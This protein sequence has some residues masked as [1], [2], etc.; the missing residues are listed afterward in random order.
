MRE[1]LDGLVPGLPEELMGRIL[2]QAEGVPLYAVETVRML[3]D[4][5][6]LTQDGSR[7]VLTGDVSELDVPETLQALS[8]ARLDGL[9]PNERSVLQDA[10]VFGQSFTAAGVAALGGRSP[11]EAER[12]LGGLVTKQLLGLN[13][14]P[15]S[16]ER[17]QYHFLQG[18]L[19]GT[20]YGTLSRRDRKARHLSA[21]RH[22]QEIWGEAAPE[23]A[24]ILAAH[25]LDAAAADPEASDAGRIRAAARDTLADAGRRALSLALGREAQRAFDRA[26]E[27]AE[28]DAS[29]AALLDQAG[30]AA[31]MSADF[32]Q[33]LTRLEEAIEIYE[34][35]GDSSAAARAMLPVGHALFREDRLDEAV[36]ILRQALIGLPD[37]DDPRAAVLAELSLMLC[38]TGDTDAALKAADA[39]LSIAEPREYWPAV[40]VAFDSLANVRVRQGRIEEARAL[41]ERAVALALENDLAETALRASNNLADISL[42]S[43]RFAEAIELAQRGYVLA[44][45]RGDH[46]W[47]SALELM[48]ASARLGRGDWDELPV[49]EDEDLSHLGE[50]MRR[51]LLP[52]FARVQA[53]RGERAELE[54]T[55]NRA[56]ET[57]DTTNREFAGSR[58]V[59]RAI[60]LRVFGRE[61][62]ALEAA[63]PVATDL[64]VPNEDRR[65]AYLEAGLAALTIG[66]EDAVRRLI[67]F[68]ESLP[69]AMRSP[70][71]RAGAARF[72]GLLALRR[73]EAELAEGRLALAL[74]ELRGIEAPF[75][76][77]Q[78]LLDR[79]EL[80]VGAGREEEAASDLAEAT[81][82]FTRLRAT[83]WLE[84][85]QAVRAGVPA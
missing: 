57:A 83:P 31:L 80:L 37:P 61:R 7:Y 58:S 69:P 39:A 54:L 6:L 15:L 10:A 30:R 45:A 76:L 85:V 42:Q 47:R 8:A 25:F 78:V 68:V 22:L 3:L 70:L 46:R 9:S 51:G 71:L 43:E 34:R 59:A 5:N 62:E 56:D 12:T 32:A 13:D 65:E 23:M 72:E 81:E 64:N 11:E 48:L 67:G 53:A 66:D 75:V 44:Q 63:M 41:R 38:F 36:E 82:I 79:A 17:G 77:G 49:Y 84:R 27:L 35:L 14:D 28:D 4:R 74:R 40:C 33:A 16:S 26:A 20:A 18:L 24:E 19:R 50:L 2:R 73:G 55:L 21:A 1:A 52:M 29:R 60:A